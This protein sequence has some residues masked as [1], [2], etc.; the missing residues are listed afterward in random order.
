MDSCIKS[1][2]IQPEGNR[3]LSGVSDGLLTSAAVGTASDVPV[4]MLLVVV[5]AEIRRGRNSSVPYDKS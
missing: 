5:A 1:G 4:A 3:L 2:D